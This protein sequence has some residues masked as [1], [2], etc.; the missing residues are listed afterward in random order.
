MTAG[1]LPMAT[2]TARSHTGTFNVMFAEGWRGNRPARGVLKKKQRDKKT[3]LFTV[4]CSR[5]GE[6]ER[7]EAHSH[8]AYSASR[9]G[10]TKAKPTYQRVTTTPTPGHR[11][12]PSQ[13]PPPPS[14]P[15]LARAGLA[16][17]STP[18]GLMDSVRHALGSLWRIR[19]GPRGTRAH[20]IAYRRKARG[21]HFV[22]PD[23]FR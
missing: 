14:S 7:G 17:S 16:R 10:G 2:A 4:G 12:H 3:V 11:P 9:K 20:T 8:A 5:I 19:S 15:P 6:Y 21:F 1:S 22:E 23:S 18:S 13:T